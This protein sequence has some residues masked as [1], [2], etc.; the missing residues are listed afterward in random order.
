MQDVSPDQFFGSQDF[1]TFTLLDVRSPGEFQEG[2]LPGAHSLPLFSNDERAKIGTLYKQQS[3]DSAMLAGLEIVG[4]KMR[5]LV[6]QAR[7]FAPNG[8]VVVHCWRGGQR[9]GSV[10]WLLEQAGMEVCRLKGGYKAARKYLRHWLAQDYH[11]FRVLSGPTGSGKTEILM[12]I[13]D[14]GHYV[15]DL[16]GLANH[17]GSSFGALGESPQPSTEAFENMLFGALREIPH[18]AGVWLE[19]ESRMIGTVYQPD[20][21]Y[22]RLTAA[23]VYV[24]EQPKAWRI[25]RL[26]RHYAHFPKHDLV[27]AFNRLRKRLGGQH[28]KAALEALER[29]DFATAAEIALFYYDKAYRYYGERREAKVVAT[30]TAPSPD[31]KEI[32]LAL[33]NLAATN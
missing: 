29:D 26:I 15:V 33:L 28:L 7:A 1:S 27:A 19:D 30:L 3:P 10:A 2:C 23:P 11:H 13:Q 18:G 16:E 4:P 9:S 22:D 6:E 32:A 21:F 5:S 20:E 12:A 25:Q 17:K 14:L 24:M 31:P 8:K